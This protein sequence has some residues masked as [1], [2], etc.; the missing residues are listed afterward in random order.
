MLQESSCGLFLWVV[1]VVPILNNEYGN[2]RIHSLLRRL[3]AIPAGLGE[4]FGDILARD[5][6]NLNDL[7]LCLQWILY[8][9]RP[10]SCDDLYLAVLVKPE[11]TSTSESPDFSKTTAR[12]VER[13]MLG[14]LKGLAGVTKSKTQKVQFIY[15]SVK[16]FLLKETHL[17]KLD[18]SL[19][20]NL[21]GL[22][23]E[24]LKQRCQARIALIFLRP[25]ERVHKVYVCI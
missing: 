25:L 8:A 16:G 19:G 15:E 13:F 10:L 21:P 4:L 22:S 23:H 18:L 17:S 9:K 2:G 7:V 14:Y 11:I 12:D 6:D 1:L 20:L 3:D 24:R 5:N